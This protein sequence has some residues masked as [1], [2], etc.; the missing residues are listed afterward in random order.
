V[1]YHNINYRTKSNLTFCNTKYYKTL[2]IVLSII[3]LTCNYHAAAQKTDTIFKN[4]EKTRLQKIDSLLSFAHQKKDNL[5]YLTLL[6]T[7]NYD[8]DRNYINLGVSLSNLAGYFQT[9]E[10][11]KIELERLRFQLLERHENQLEKL[12]IDYENL[13][14]NYEILILE[15]KNNSY[16]K[17]LFNL[18]KQQYEK[19]KITLEEWLNIQN[20]HHQ[21]TLILISKKNKLITEMKSFQVKIKSSCFRQELEYLTNGPTQIN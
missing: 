21:N 7:L 5:K 1:I 12:E 18:K 6:P 4:Y 11:N 15:I 13:K 8:F 17:D 3:F 9:K 2:T 19:N 16:A 10:R 20:Q 14:N